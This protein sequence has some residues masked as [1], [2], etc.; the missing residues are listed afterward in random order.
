MITRDALIEQRASKA[1]MLRQ[2][3]D[4]QPGFVGMVV[5]TTGA[6]R[7][8]GDGTYASI[9]VLL[10]RDGSPFGHERRFATSELIRIDDR[11]TPVWSSQG[12]HYDLTFEEAE[13]DLRTR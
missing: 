2:I 12:G 10:E 5:L 6:F 9:M 11:E 4:D 1:H 13:E 7:P 8:G 3:H